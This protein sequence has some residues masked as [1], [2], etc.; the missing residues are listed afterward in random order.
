MRKNVGT[1]KSRTTELPGP[2]DYGNERYRVKMQWR[3]IN[4]VNEFEMYM[5][6]NVLP[7]VVWVREKGISRRVTGLESQRHVVI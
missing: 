1:K 4:E 7:I 6:V 3:F 5:R 2:D